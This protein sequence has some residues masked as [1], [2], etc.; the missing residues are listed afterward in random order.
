M[1]PVTVLMT[2][3]RMLDM[4]Y[5]ISEIRDSLNVGN[6]T[7]YRVRNRMA[8]SNVDF[9]KL[10]ELPLTEV[11]TLFYGGKN[12]LRHNIPL[13]DFAPIYERINCKKARTNLLME[14]EDYIGKFPDGYKY[15][16]FKVHYHRWVFEN[17]GPENTA[18]LQNRKPGYYMYLDW[19]GVVLPLVINPDSPSELMKAHLFV[20]TIGFSSKIFVKAYPNEKTEC[21]L[22][23][24]NSALEFYGALPQAFRPD[25]MKTAVTK[26]TKDSLVLSKAFY[27]LQAYYDIPVVPA[28]P[29]KPKGK[30]SVERGVQWIE[31]RVLGKIKKETFATYEDLNSRIQEIVIGLNAKVKT[32]TGKTRNQLFN[33]FDLPEMGPLPQMP[34][35]YVEYKL[36]T[37]P[38]NYHI[39]Y[40]S[41]YYSV[42]YRLYNKNN[43]TPVMA[44]IKRNEID[45]CDLNNVIIVTH[46]ICNDPTRLYITERD[47]MPPNHQY[48]ADG[49]GANQAYY[50]NWA[51]DVGLSMKEFIERLFQRYDYPPQAYKSC[52]A[53]FAKVKQITYSEANKAAAVCLERNTISVTG[54]DRA[55]KANNA[56]SRGEGTTPYNDN[57]RGKDYYS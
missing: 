12:C 39:N 34:F 31:Q 28:P 57:V 3:A 21:V 50:L 55:L 18:M 19:A 15:T 44:K 47:H 13:P 42:P 35:E 26:N 11:E 32:G 14:W 41:H 9:L 23:A 40:N 54:Y 45:I 25:N 6:S 1:K 8:E 27:D 22:D 38:S 29:L 17:I 43:P 5:S 48:A 16:Q 52:Q 33:E 46:P 20:V 37:V 24:V 56:R 10:K 36:Y 7:I 53:I 2:I 49:E 51:R 30:P 4:E